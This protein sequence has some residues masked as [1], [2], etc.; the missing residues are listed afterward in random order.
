M[1]FFRAMSLLERGLFSSP[2]NFHIKI[3]LVRT[4]LEAGLVGSADNAFTLLDI[5]H[6]Q[7]DS[8]GYL[9]VPL[10]AP[11]GH[12]SLAST[13]L[14][15][16]TKFFIANYKDVCIIKNDRVIIFIFHSMIFKYKR[17]CFKNSNKK[18]THTSCFYCRVQII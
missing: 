4:Y 7:L 2:A 14:D 18:T 5:K 3:L 1:G 12:L 11:L 8:L 16:S 10:L 6:I 15:H 9:H 13:T 17:T